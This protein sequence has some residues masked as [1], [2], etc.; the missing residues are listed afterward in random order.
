MVFAIGSERSIENI[1]MV[2]KPV[3]A[4]DNTIKERD[5]EHFDHA[6]TDLT[7]ACNSCHQAGQVGFIVIQI[8]T[9]FPFSSQ[10]FEPKQR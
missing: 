10:D 9:A 7:A 6:F 2:G 4:L 1:I 5:G 3:Q 8:P